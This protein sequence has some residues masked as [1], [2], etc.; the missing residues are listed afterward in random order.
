V[1][2]F[3]FGQINFPGRLPA[4]GMESRRAETAPRAPFT[5]VRSPP[6]DAPAFVLKHNGR[7]TAAGKIRTA[8]TGNRVSVT[9]V[10]YGGK[11]E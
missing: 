11:S 4:Q 1:L 3:F 9:A 10:L 2:I 5:T 8:I 6:G 7:D